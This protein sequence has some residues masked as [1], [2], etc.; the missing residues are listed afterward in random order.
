[1]DHV[2]LL[3]ECAQ[4]LIILVLLKDHLDVKLEHALLI[5]TVV[6]LQMDV[7]INIHKDVLKLDYVL[8]I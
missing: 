5:L 2:D 6:Q 3:K 7:I 4:E 8:K 1:M